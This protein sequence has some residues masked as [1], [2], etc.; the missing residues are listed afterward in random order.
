MRDLLWTAHLQQPLVKTQLVP[1]PSAG[2]QKAVHPPAFRVVDLCVRYTSAQ[3]LPDQTR[4]EI[5]IH[6]GDPHI[7]ESASRSSCGN[8]IAA[9]RSSRSVVIGLNPRGQE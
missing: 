6:S 5:D 3:R 9:L 7:T 4:L 2:D 1:Q 8:R